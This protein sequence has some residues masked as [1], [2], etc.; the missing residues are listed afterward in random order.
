M[1]YI[2][3]T[4]VKET[5]TIQNTLI[6]TAHTLLGTLPRKSPGHSSSM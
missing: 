4:T 5:F 6:E 2:H 1:N 3:N